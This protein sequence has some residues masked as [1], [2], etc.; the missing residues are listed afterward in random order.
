MNPSEF[1]LIFAIGVMSVDLA[2]SLI[3]RKEVGQERERSYSA[4]Y[5]MSTARKIQIAAKI[6]VIMLL[7][8]TL[9]LGI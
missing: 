1:S 8:F 5:K 3:F 4:F 7:A 9:I 2:Y 6:L